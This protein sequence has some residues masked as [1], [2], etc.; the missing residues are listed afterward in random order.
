MKNFS[1]I[2]LIIICLIGIWFAGCTEDGGDLD[3]DENELKVIFSDISSGDEV[4]TYTDLKLEI[5]VLDQNDQGVIDADVA[6]SSSEGS[7]DIQSGKTYDQ[8]G[9]G[10]FETT[11]SPPSVNK[12][13]EVWITARVSKPGIGSGK[14]SITVVIVPWYN[15]VI[16]INAKLNQGNGNA[17]SGV[18]FEIKKGSGE[19]V[20]IADYIF[21]VCE[22]GGPLHTL[23]WPEDGNTTAYSLD[24]GL[25]ANDGDW[26]DQT[27]IIGFDAPPGLTGVID[28]D[29]IEV[30]IIHI[31]T[32]NIVYSESFTH[33]D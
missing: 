17:T 3:D 7:F 8:N 18:L 11:Y 24:S 12:E 33:R 2:V 22:K 10:I 4:S 28:G 25:K 23:K 15:E 32:G 27:E 31:N 29:L 9:L 1:I 26:W 13:T 21:K 16:Y 5:I 14:S 30:R 20:E 19:S 6:I